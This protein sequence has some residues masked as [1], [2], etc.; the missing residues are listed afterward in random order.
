MGLEAGRPGRQLGEEAHPLTV[1]VQG[2]ETEPFTVVGTGEPPTVTAQLLTVTSGGVW[3]DGERGDIKRGVV[4]A[5]PSTTLFFKPE[6]SDSAGR[7]QASWCWLPP[8]APAG[9]PA[10]DVCA[11]RTA[12]DMS[13]AQLCLGQRGPGIR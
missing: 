12:A 3:I 1:P 9:T 2:G 13:L 4:E 6:G 7:V 11:A 8:S 5:P 10:C